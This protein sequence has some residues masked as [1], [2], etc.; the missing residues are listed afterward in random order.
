M[1]LKEVSRVFQKI[2]EGFSR[3]L[4]GCINGVLNGFQGCLKEVQWV[5]WES[6]KGV[7]RKC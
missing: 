6:F 2:F 4:G 3:K 5:F 7:S 1:R